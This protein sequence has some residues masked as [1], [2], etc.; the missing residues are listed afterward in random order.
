VGVTA[1]T[2]TSQSLPIGGLWEIAVSIVDSDGLV[3]ATA[4]TVTV[5]L[6]D[7]TTATPTAEDEEAGY[8]RASVTIT[9]PGRY[10][11]RAVAAG[12]GAA[13]FTAWASAVVPGSGMPDLAAADN[14][15][16][17]NSWTDDEIE[18]ALNAEAAAQRSVCD[19]PADYPDDLR[20]ALLRRVARNLSLRKLPLAVLV[21]DAENGSTVL[22]GRDPEVRRLE[23]PFRRMVTG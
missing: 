18:D 5:T 3:S 10:V 1:R 8:F 7:G 20:Q 21:G 2:S 4:P 14:Y 17:D 22:P 19:V 6:P 23:A 13:D 15:L 16:G 11:A 9:L 12:Y